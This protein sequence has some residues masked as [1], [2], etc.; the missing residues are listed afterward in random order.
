MVERWKL[1]AD[2]NSVDVSV[3]VEDAGAFT[4]PW[5]AVHRWRRAEGAD[6]DGPC[7]ENNPDFYNQ[8]LAP[9]PQASTP[10]F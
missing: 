9:I 7:N 3:F 8:G 1:A 5:M 4:T 6:P 10:D 2:G